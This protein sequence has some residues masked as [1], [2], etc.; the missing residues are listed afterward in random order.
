MAK[1]FFDEEYDKKTQQSEQ[2][3]TVDSWYSHPAPAQASSNKS[4]PLYIVILCVALVLCFAL[5]WVL[6]YVF[7]GLGKSA[8]DEGG[9]I[10]KTVIDYLQNNYYKDIP[11]EQWSRAIELSGTALMQYAGDRFS[12]LMSPQ[13]YYDFMYPTSSTQSN[14]EIFGLSMSVNEGVGLYVSSITANSNAYGKFFPGDIILRLTDIVGYNG[15][16]SIE[17]ADGEVKFEQINLGQWASTTIQAVLSQVK[18]ATFHVLRWVDEGDAH[19]EIKQIELARGRITPVSSQYN[20]T[21]VEFYF[22]SEHRN[23]SVPSRK[24]SDGNYVI[25]EGEYTTYQERNLDKLPPQT[26]YIRID[27]FMDYTQTGESGSLTTVSAS[28]EFKTVMDLF[29]RLGLKHLVLDLKGNP[30]GNV[31]YVTEIAGML[32]TSAKLTTEQRKAVTNSNNELLITYLEIPKPAKV[33]QNYYQASSYNDYFGAIGSKCDIVV[34]TDGN[35]AS[36]SE[37]LTGTLRDYGTAVQMGTTS[38]GKGIAQTW[39]ELPFTG[40][41]TTLNKETIDFPWAVYYTCASYYSP[42]G[43]NIHGVGYTPE[44]AYNNLSTYLELWTATNNY[45]AA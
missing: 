11:D 36:A 23:I 22:D 33:K 42:L 24:D 26:G 19:F 35:S 3:E 27:Q 17:G 45:W 6:S 14:G 5:G 34:W 31:S 12:Q 25:T 2:K 20:Y 37:L 16:P 44:G 13:T 29:A 21:F 18:K 7:Q 1:D 8:A 30:G 4:R 15:T 9:D 39:Q 40:K 38:Y 43:T 10:L 41:V 32:V 28:Q